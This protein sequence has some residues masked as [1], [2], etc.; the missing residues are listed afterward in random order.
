MKLFKA[1]TPITSLDFQA[2]LHFSLHLLDLF[3]FSYFDTF[4]R[5]ALV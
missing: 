5:E 1:L 2:N 3:S 4:A